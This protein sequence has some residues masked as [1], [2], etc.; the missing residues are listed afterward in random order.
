MQRNW[1]GKSAGARVRFGIVGR[2]EPLEVFTTRP[3]TLFGASF[4][5]IA[6][7]H[8]LAAELAA[9]RTPSWPRSSPSA[10]SGGT[11]EAEIE[12]QEKR[13]FDTGL[14]LPPSVRSGPTDLPVYVANF[15]LM[16]YGTGAIFGCPAHDQRDLDFAR[17]YGLPVM[18]VVLPPGADPA[19][20]RDRR[21]G[22]CRRRHA[23][24]LGASSTGWTSRPPSAGPS[25]SWSGCGRGERRDHLSAARLGRLAPA[26]LGLP[27][28]GDPLRALRRRPGAARAAAR[29]PARGRRLRAARQ[30]AR[31]PPDLE[32]RRL[33]DL[34]R[35]GRARDRHLRHLRRE[36]L[37]LRPL[38]LARRRPSGRSRRD[39]VD[40]W[41]PVDQYIGGVE[42]AVLHLLY[43]RFFTRAMSSL[44]PCST[45]TSRSPAC[46][47]RAWSPT[48]PSSD[49]HGDWLEPGEVARD[50]AGG[51]V[52][53]DG[54]RPVHGRPRREDEQVQAQ[55]GRSRGRSSRPTGPTR[56]ACSCSPTARPSATWNGP[57]PASTAPGATST[58]SGA[59][60]RSGSASCRRPARPR[61]ATSGPRRRR[62]QAAGPPHHRRP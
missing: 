1:I 17:R 38:L 11:S 7:D 55:H 41:L 51:W 52:T 21:R 29:D 61:P 33:P 22:L 5:A 18:P 23:L 9:R 32:A 54:R 28:P 48:S 43:A 46:S 45:W 16:D 12:T 19:R 34:R 2:D 14:Q 62:A 36:L 40:Y 53:V 24:P 60:S 57:T 31:P 20:V 8:P 30:P 49:A 4:V 39:A 6:P 44:R 26:L 13:G 42:H 56:R 25:T 10:C 37:V 47:R 50:E 3:D 35:P 27:D 15:V 59:W 58:A